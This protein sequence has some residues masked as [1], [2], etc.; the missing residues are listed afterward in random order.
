M[1][2]RRCWTKSNWVRSVQ[3]SSLGLTP[4]VSVCDI[5]IEF[6]SCAKPIIIERQKFRKRRSTEAVRQRENIPKKGSDPLY[7]QV[8]LR[9]KRPSATEKDRTGW[10]KGESAAE[11]VGSRA[12]RK[13][14]PAV[15]RGDRPA[16]KPPTSEKAPIGQGKGSR[17][18]KCR[19]RIP[20]SPRRARGEG[21][22]TAP[23]SDAALY[24]A[25]IGC[26]LNSLL[27]S[28]R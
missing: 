18:P 28:K 7:S 6:T 1:G 15:G 17:R 26:R 12:S 22:P 2:F 11:A 16:K 19:S 10:G 5:H 13:P 9:G 14:G 3:C 4:I 25:S 8:L 20:K 21:R 24:C 23:T 27:R